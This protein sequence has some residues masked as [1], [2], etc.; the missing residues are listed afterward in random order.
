M[1]FRDQQLNMEPHEE[2]DEISLRTNEDG[3]VD[4]NILGWEKTRT[5][6]SNGLVAKVYF[7]KPNGKVED[8]EMPWPENNVEKYKF[9]RFINETPH[10]LRTANKIN[11]DEDIWIKAD[12]ESWEL[13]LPKE[14]T[15]KEKISK[16]IPEMRISIILIQ[17]I[18][19]P[20]M[21]FYRA[22]DAD[23]YKQKSNH[24]RKSPDIT[25]LEAKYCSGFA[26][27][28]FGMLLWCFMI[29]LIYNWYF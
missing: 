22:K 9:I 6:Y 27:G 25:D 26:W 1:D 16:R 13:I 5:N 2:L 18:I 4:V 14:K 24:R 12:P 15:L 7:R 19:L 29:L 10:T 11:N 21:M 23:Q 3:T 28:S 20:A 17:F 8:E